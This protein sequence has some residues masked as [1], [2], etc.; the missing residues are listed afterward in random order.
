MKSVWLCGATL[1]PPHSPQRSLQRK[2]SSRSS[3]EEFLPQIR[4]E[5]SWM[6]DCGVDHLVTGACSSMR[7]HISN[8]LFPSISSPHS[9]WGGHERALGGDREACFAG[10][11]HSRVLRAQGLAHTCQLAFLPSI[12]CLPTI[13][14]NVKNL[15]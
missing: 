5:Q 3:S 15:V 7:L 8:P 11:E 10:L 4:T 13:M 9:G 1:C 12:S 6:Q 2:N 14:C